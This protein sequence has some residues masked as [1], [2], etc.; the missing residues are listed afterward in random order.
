MSSIATP[1]ELIRAI[2]LTPKAFTRVVK[3][4]R[5]VPSTTAFSAADLPVPSPMNWNQD[6]ICGSVTWY[7]SATADSDTMVAVTIIQPPSQ[8]MCGPPSFLDQL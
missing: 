4:M 2:S 5:M 7:A 6:E 3:V 8:P 1:A